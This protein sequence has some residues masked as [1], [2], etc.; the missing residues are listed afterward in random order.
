MT[1]TSAGESGSFGQVLEPRQ[2]FLPAAEVQPGGG[3]VE[4]QQLGVGHHRPGDQHPLAFAFG[5]RAVGAFGEVFGADAFQHVDGL[6]VVDVLIVLTPPAHHRVA[7][8][9]DQVAHHFTVGHALGERRAAQPDTRAQFGHVDAAEP[10][11]E[12]ERGARRR[13]LQGRG[14][15]QQ[16]RLAGPVRPD[17]HPAFVEFDRPGDG[18]DQRLAT[19]SQ[20]DFG[21]VDQQVGV[22][23]IFFGDGHPTIVPYSTHVAF[24]GSDPNR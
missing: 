24:C 11:A 19:A 10:L 12:H 20:C 14:D 18:P 5:E 8:G 3:L 2:Q 9:D 4:Q 23:R 15:A 16:R 7:G 17:D 1:S 22:G 13:V 6:L 21:E